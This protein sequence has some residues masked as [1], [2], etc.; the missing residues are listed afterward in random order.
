MLKLHLLE[1][2][3]IS[4]SHFGIIMRVSE[5]PKKTQ[6][7]VSATN[8]VATIWIAQNIYVWWMMF[9]SNNVNPVRWSDIESLFN[10]YF[11]TISEKT[12]SFLLS[13]K[14]KIRTRVLCR[15]LIK[16]KWYSKLVCFEFHQLTYPN[17]KLLSQYEIN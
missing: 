17:I 11:W 1:G 2:I 6:K 7:N 4:F 14:N 9:K 13:Y 15:R 10:E 5:F 3:L 8:I 12:I 16:S